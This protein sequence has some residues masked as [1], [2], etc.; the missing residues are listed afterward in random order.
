MGPLGPKGPC[1]FVGFRF[2][3]YVPGPL[4]RYI[5]TALGP[6]YMIYRIPTWTFGGLRTL[7]I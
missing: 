5:G 6:K 7:H 4:G 3:C 1:S 2:I